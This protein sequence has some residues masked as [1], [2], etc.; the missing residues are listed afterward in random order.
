MAKLKFLVE[1]EVDESW[2][3]DGFNP[4]DERAKSM[5]AHTLPHA[6]G[7]ELKARVLI[8]IDQE[9][10]AKLMGYASLKAM[11]NER[12]EDGDQ[13]MKPVPMVRWKLW[14]LI[15]DPFVAVTG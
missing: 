5:L 3:A 12:K 7:S 10:A 15:K 11:I 8:P 9:K 2:V 13:I 4:D 6:H 1:F 14:R